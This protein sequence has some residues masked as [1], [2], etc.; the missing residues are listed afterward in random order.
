MTGRA[1]RILGVDP[2]SRKTG[3]GVVECTGRH[4]AIRHVDNGVFMLSE[5]APLAERLRELSVGLADVIE[6][7]RPHHAAVEDVFVHKGP[8]SALILGQARG[9]ALATLALGRVPVTAFA[10]T[11][12]KARITGRGRASKLQVAD[13]VCVLLGL[14]E[15]PFEDAADALAIA[16]C[17]AMSLQS[18]VP[19]APAK[20]APPRRGGVRGGLAELARAQGKIP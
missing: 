16:L 9:A 8:R 10:S 19:L 1:Q 15:H 12:V 18:P 20:K 5:G 6:R 14:A 17:H 13:M 11:Q 3:W 2:G 4:A 7:H